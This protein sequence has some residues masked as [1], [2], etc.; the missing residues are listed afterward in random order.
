MKRH[1][2][3]GLVGIALG[4]MAMQPV[5]RVAAGDE[6]C[7]DDPYITIGGQTIHINV[8]LPPGIS[9]NAGVNAGPGGNG[10]T[11]SSTTVGVVNVTVT[12]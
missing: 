5:S 1:I 7:W 4:V 11:A 6:W 8:L 2:I 3:T 12:K 10:A 9:A